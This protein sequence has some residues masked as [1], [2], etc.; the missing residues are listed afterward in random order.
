MFTGS[1]P[2]ELG[3]LTNARAIIIGECG[4]NYVVYEI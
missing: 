2:T 4:S 3:K 1:L